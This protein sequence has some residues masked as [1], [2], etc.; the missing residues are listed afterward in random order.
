MEFTEETQ[1]AMKNEDEVL[2]DG[3][4]KLRM[5]S[6]DPQNHLLW[7]ER[8]KGRLSDNHNTK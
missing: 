4:K 5:D 2:M 8:L 6:A 1:Q 3:R 7:K